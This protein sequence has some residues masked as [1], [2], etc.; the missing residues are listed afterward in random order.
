MTNPFATAA[1]PAAAANPFA[2]Q[3]QPTP[4]V[5]Q[6]QATAPTFTPPVAQ[7]QATAP[8]PGG[9]VDPFGAV[10][11]A[12]AFDGLSS[13]DA[14]GN[15]TVVALRIN[16]YEEGVMSTFRDEKTGEPIVQ[17]RLTVDAKVVTGP[18]AGKTFPD[19]WLF[20]RRVVAQFKDCAGNGQWYLVHLTKS[21]RAVVA[22]PVQDPGMRAEA[23]KL[24]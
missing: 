19:T 1:Q 8:A 24:F 9:P 11:D 13:D 4:P 18:K 6:P 15:G 22:N 5:A 14:A 2:A 12:P 17:N 7:P 21:G 20:W 3:A 23:A 16:T 10:P